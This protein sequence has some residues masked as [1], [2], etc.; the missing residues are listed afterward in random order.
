MYNFIQRPLKLIAVFVSAKLPSGFYEP[1]GYLRGA[2]CARHQFHG[3]A[4][5]APSR[6]ALA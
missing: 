2:T 1:L 5:V 3:T 6:S 4:A